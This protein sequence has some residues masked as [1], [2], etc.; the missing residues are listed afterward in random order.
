M[1]R[2]MSFQF[3]TL[4]A[5]VAAVR[6]LSCMYSHVV[7]QIALTG[8]MFA[9]YVTVKVCLVV[10]RLAFMRLEVPCKHSFFG[11][12]VVAYVAAI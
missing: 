12:Y 1:F 11:E 2:H 4:A 10:K 6:S 7:L 3:K 9:T 8:Y 5:E